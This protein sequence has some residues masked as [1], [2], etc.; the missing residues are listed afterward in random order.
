MT[1]AQP[2]GIGV[3]VLVALALLVCGFS[4]LGLLVMRGFYNKLH[5]LAPPAILATA[6]LAAAVGLQE[7][8]GSS[9]VKVL[10]VLLVMIVGNP[11]VTFAAAR[12]HY[13]REEMRGRPGK[14]E[15]DAEEPEEVRGGE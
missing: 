6:A 14:R 15:S 3:A 4:C 2:T 1:P 10:L 9:T 13:L 11:V 8:W 7:G 5:F 12:A